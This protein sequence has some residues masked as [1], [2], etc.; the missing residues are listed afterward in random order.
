MDLTAL[1]SDYKNGKLTGKDLATLQTEGKI[2]KSERRSIV[3]KASKDSSSS[4]SSSASAAGG[5][6]SER[7]KLRLMVKEKKA[8]P[9]QKLSQ[10]ERDAKFSL[11]EKLERDRLREE[12]NFVICLGCRKRGH[13]LK[14]CP[15]KAAVE[16]CYNCGEANHA[17]RDCPKPRSKDGS[18][19]FASCFVCKQKGHITKD[20]PQN[21]NGLYPKG[22]CCH[23]CLQKTH[24]VKDCPERTEE[25]IEEWQRQKRQKEQDE[26]DAD[27][28]PRIK[29]LTEGEGLAGD[30]DMGEFGE[31]ADDDEDG[32]DPEDEEGGGGSK[33]RKSSKAKGKKNKKPKK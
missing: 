13:F 21:P 23:I 3:K 27:L 16:V 32:D 30:D 9:K 15:K 24:F 18:L 33:K 5:E 8:Q 22:G 11:G 6:L 26:E 29:G 14:D 10:E 12:A 25:D 19:R 17:L 2:S 1:I 28:G 20:C 4:S 7:Q 31:Q